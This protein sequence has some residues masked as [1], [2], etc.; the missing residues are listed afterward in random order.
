MVIIS[1][2]TDFNI[3]EET[4][5]SIG[6]FDGLHK[7]HLMI[8]DRMNEYRAHGLK[9]CVMTFDN[10]PA[11][12]GFGNDNKTLMTMKEKE[13]V[14]NAYGIDYLVEFPFNEKTAATD[15][16][17]FIEEFIVN[18]MHARAVVV[19][20]DCS[21]GHKALGDANMLRDYGPKYGYDVEILSKLLDGDREISSTYI[22]ELV[23]EGNVAKAYELSYRPY[24][25]N[26]KLK[27]NI[28]GCNS[29]LLYYY[30]NVSDDK[31]L[32][33]PG[34][35]YS[36]ILYE[37][38]LYPGMT[39]IAKD[40]RKVYT[41]VYGAVKGISREVVTIVLFDKMHDYVEYDKKADLNAAVKKD[42]FEGQKWHKEHPWSVV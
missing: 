14:F 40:S 1:G 31:I 27:K 18:K 23:S 4:V 17:D 19:G 21:F 8:L 5:V 16:R 34:M 42:I 10:P 13:Q 41:Y 36:N 37:D 25:I 32:P 20:E 28:L 29:T 39:C 15:A 7:G 6:K 9:M 33:N 12:L 3:S 24:I 11:S 35:Y 22:R 30:M 2:T 38:A 26:G